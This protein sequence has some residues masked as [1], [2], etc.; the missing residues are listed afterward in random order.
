MDSPSS[1]EALTKCKA[2]RSVSSPLQWPNSLSVMQLCEIHDIRPPCKMNANARLV[3]LIVSILVGTTYVPFTRMATKGSGAFIELQR[4]N[5][6]R[7]RLSTDRERS[8]NML[9]VSVNQVCS[10]NDCQFVVMYR[11]LCSP[12]LQMSIPL[13]WLYCHHPRPSHVPYGAALPTLHL[14]PLCKKQKLPLSPIPFCL[15]LHFETNSGAS[16]K[17]KHSHHAYSL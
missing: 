15:S 13:F 6:I 5:Q 16:C 2:Y 11:S 7:C 14:I 8:S 4:S 12:P 17:R 3:C 9:P 1:T 10:R